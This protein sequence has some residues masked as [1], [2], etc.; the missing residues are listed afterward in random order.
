MALGAIAARRAVIL[1][2]LTKVADRLA[3]AE[4]SA[5]TTATAHADNLAGINDDPHLHEAFVRS[6]VDASIRDEM[7]HAVRMIRYAVDRLSPRRP[8]KR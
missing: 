8:G 3:S 6:Y 4:S 1:D 7:K 5:T 2:E